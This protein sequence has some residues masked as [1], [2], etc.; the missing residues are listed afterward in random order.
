LSPIVLV[1]LPAVGEP[2]LAFGKP[3]CGVSSRLNQCRSRRSGADRR[4]FPAGASGGSEIGAST[5]AFH[6][7]SAPFLQT[8]T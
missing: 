5:T 4:H 8:T 7:P 1:I 2:M 3:N 6:A